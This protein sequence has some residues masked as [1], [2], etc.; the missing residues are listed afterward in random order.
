[1]DNYIEHEGTVIFSEGDKLI[2]RIEQNSA[3]SGCHA[4]S[5]CTAAD[6]ADKEIEAIPYGGKVFHVGEKVLLR[7]SDHIGRQAVLLAFVLP[8][9]FMLLLL[10]IFMALFD[11]EGIAGIASLLSLIPYYIVLYLK[12]EVLRKKFIFEVH[13]LS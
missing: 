7:G 2:V 3:C 12:R 6:R 1:M 10:A 11:H 5:A 9:I 8:F 4:K 13:K